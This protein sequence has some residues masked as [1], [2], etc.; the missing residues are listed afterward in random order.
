MSQTKFP[1]T[2]TL[3]LVY[4]LIASIAI[5]SLILASSLQWISNP[6]N[7]TNMII[8]ATAFI[9]FGLGTVLNS[10]KSKF[11]FIGGLLLILFGLSIL[12]WYAVPYLR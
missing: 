2:E 9:I 4:I 8:L 6:L 3:G 1:K 5:T 12:A 7:E 11:Y 10:Y